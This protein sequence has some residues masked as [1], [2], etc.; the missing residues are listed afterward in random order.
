[1]EELQGH[2]FNECRE[3]KG[4]E[5]K[6]EDWKVWSGGV[7]HPS[8]SPP[9]VQPDKDSGALWETGSGEESL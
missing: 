9:L 5:K 8:A 6:R 1:M 7:S 2:T 4:G 3:V